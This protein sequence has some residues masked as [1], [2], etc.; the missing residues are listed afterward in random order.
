MT[1]YRDKLKRLAEY[2]YYHYTGKRG[3]CLYDKPVSK[4]EYIEHLNFWKWS[5]T[6]HRLIGGG[7]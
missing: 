3:V 4:E 7:L 1:D 5:R 6:M 2:N